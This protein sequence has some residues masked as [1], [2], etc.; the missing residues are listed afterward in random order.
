MFFATICTLSMGTGESNT[1]RLLNHFKENH[2]RRT[3]LS[4]RPAANQMQTEVRQLDIACCECVKGEIQTLWSTRFT[5]AG[6]DSRNNQHRG[7]AQDSTLVFLFVFFKSIH[8]ITFIHVRQPRA[9]YLFPCLRDRNRPVTSTTLGLRYMCLSVR[10]F[11]L[12]E[13]WVFFPHTHTHAHWGVVN[14]LHGVNTLKGHK[15]TALKPSL[16]ISVT[17]LRLGLIPR[18]PPSP[19]IFEM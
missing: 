6:H 2:P 10:V 7:H 1:T 14:G 16:Q 15:V 3:S 19:Q 5:N 13:V 18:P 17:A 4:S 9:L 12:I 8:Y 11:V